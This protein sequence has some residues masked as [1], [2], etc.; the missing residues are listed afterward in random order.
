[1]L[2]L[3]KLNRTHDLLCDTLALCIHLPVLLLLLLV[4]PTMFNPKSEVK[5]KDM[6]Q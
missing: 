4:H 2:D 6:R 5:W 1:M 3:G